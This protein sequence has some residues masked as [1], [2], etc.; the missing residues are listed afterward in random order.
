MYP[1]QGNGFRFNDNCHYVSLDA[2]EISNNEGDGIQL[3]SGLNQLSF[4]NNALRGNAFASVSGSPGSDLEWLDNTVS[5]NGS[6]VELSSQG[7]TDRKPVAAFTCPATVLVG[8]PVSFWG[9]SHD[10]DGFI[11][12]VLWDFGDGIPATGFNATHTYTRA[13]SRIITLVVW[14]NLGRG[15]LASKTIT[16]ADK[17]SEE[18]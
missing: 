18:Q 8:Q 1:N 9:K 15:M 7:F 5:G 14:D 2:N 17:P 16:V 3:S 10:P 4:T 12:H 11:A 6:D 13:G